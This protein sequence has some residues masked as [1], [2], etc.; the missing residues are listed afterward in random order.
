MVNLVDVNEKF[1]GDLST[2]ITEQKRNF[3]LFRSEA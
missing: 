2:Q 3:E 1:N